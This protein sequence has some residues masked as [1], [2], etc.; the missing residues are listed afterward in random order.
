MA[1]SRIDVLAVAPTRVRGAS[2]GCHCNLRGNTQLIAT[3][4]VR[5][6]GTWLSV[7]PAGNVA[8]SAYRPASG[9]P[10]LMCRR[11]VGDT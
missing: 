11:S 6:C 9:H 7:E 1:D 8:S 3:I 2:K 4:L 5:S 10:P